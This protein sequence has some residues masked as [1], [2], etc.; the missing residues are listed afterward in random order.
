MPA[1]E[2]V[3]VCIRLFFDA[4]IKDQ[5]RIIGFGPADKRLGDAPEISACLRLRSQESCNS[6]MTDLAVKQLRQT[7]R[8]CLTERAD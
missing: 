4:V 8:S 6:I 7:G 3:L 1:D 5:Y 2:V